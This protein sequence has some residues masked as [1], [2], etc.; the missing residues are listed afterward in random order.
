MV[1]LIV[2]GGRDFD[3]YVLAEQ[4]LLYYTGNVDGNIIIISGGCDDKKG[5]HTFT[6]KDGTKVYGA[7]GLGER[8]ASEYLIDVQIFLADWSVYGKSAGP[9]RNGEMAD[10]GTHCICFWDGLSRGTADMIKKAK[11]KGLK[12]RV[13]NY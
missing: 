4:K 6:R 9:R 13:V 8:F 1:K 3:N 7:D 12:T 11:S 5:K 10:Y 2:A